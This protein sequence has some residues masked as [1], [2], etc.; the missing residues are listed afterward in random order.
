MQNRHIDG[1][2]AVRIDD[3]VLTGRYDLVYDSMV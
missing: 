3:G 2:G 1:R